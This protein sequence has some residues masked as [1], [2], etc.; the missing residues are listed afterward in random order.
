[1]DSGK[2]ASFVNEPIGLA[3]TSVQPRWPHVT[4]ALLVTVRALG[5][6]AHRTSLPL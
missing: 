6:W 3:V 5:R 2:T 1:M 4:F